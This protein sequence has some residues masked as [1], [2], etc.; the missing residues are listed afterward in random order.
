[1]VIS[2]RRTRWH[3]V[4]VATALGQGLGD[5]AAMRT[6][7]ALLYLLFFRDARGQRARR[8]EPCLE[9]TVLC[10]ASAAWAMVSAAMVLLE[11]LNGSRM[12]F[13][14]LAE[15]GASTFPYEGSAFPRT[16]TVSLIVPR[17]SC[18]L[19]VHHSLDRAP[20]PVLGDLFRRPLP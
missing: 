2:P 10:F 11:S 1:M 7:G 3:I 9:L 20:H 8:I 18:H 6:F 15:P 4:A 13:A 17:S 12:P 5:L 16:W 14:R 19:P